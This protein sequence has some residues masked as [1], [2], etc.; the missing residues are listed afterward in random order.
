MTQWGFRLI[1]SLLNGTFKTFSFIPFFSE[2]SVCP[3]LANLSGGATDKWGTQR[4][5]L[6][7]PSSILNIYFQIS[8]YALY[9]NCMLCLAYLLR[10]TAKAVAVLLPILG[11]S[12]IFGVLA[13]N[14][15]SLLFQYMF[16]VFNSLQVSL[17]PGPLF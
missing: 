15:Q 11:I 10:L 1:F 16:A 5:A 8:N 17:T 13:I 4:I 14:D 6:H 12:W 7:N 2:G 3:S 9:S